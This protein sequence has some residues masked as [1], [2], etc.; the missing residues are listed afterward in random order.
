MSADRLGI[1][2]SSTALASIGLTAVLAPFLSRYTP[3]T[4][5]WEHLAISP[6]LI[7]GHWFGTD[8]LGRDLFVRTMLGVRLSLVIGIVSGILSLAIGIAWGTIAGLAGARTDSLM[9]RFVDVLYSLPYLFLVIIL[10][11]L[12]GRGNLA[13]LLIA[14][15]AV[16][17][18]TTAR[19]VRGQTMAVRRQE[20]IEAAAAMGASRRRIIW[21]H[22]LPNI[23]RPV[24]AYGI[25]TVPQMILFESFLSF[26]GLGV[27]EP[28]ASL[29]SLLSEGAQ[30]MESA[31]WMLIA[32]S[33]FLV[34]VLVCLNFIGDAVKLGRNH[35]RQ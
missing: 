18:L 24:L 34:A 23:V 25:L 1:A 26:L 4:L 32:P 17:W 30:E 31:P 20:F 16:G 15:A 2:A 33:V 19:I 5:D 3:W 9:M 28:A 27:Q 8:R 21:R 35:A 7:S 29:G 6:S 13:V 10:T 22:V 11:T 12:I 14:I